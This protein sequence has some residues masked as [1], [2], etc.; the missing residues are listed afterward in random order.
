MQTIFLFGSIDVRFVDVMKTLIGS[1]YLC[2]FR[3]QFNGLPISKALSDI[4]FG[5]HQ[6]Q[7]QKFTIAGHEQHKCFVNDFRCGRKNIKLFSTSGLATNS[8]CNLFHEIVV[9]LFDS[10]K[11]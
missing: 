11:L 5:I 6:R 9:A 10:I 2:A 1:V 8:I 7:N 4:G 3:N